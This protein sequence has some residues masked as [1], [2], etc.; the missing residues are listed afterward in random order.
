MDIL[1]PIDQAEGTKKGN[2]LENKESLD[3]LYDT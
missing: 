1:P 2:P 3:P